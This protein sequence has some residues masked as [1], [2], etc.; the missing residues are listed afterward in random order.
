MRFWPSFDGP[1]LNTI[2][3]LADTMRAD[4]AVERCPQGRLGSGGGKEERRSNNA[5]AYVSRHTPAW[6]HGP[7]RRLLR[8]I[9]GCPYFP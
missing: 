7:K 9:H 6:W 3:T 8:G 4:R 5:P 2:W 1:W